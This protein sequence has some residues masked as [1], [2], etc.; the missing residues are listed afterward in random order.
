MTAF[1]T[2]GR[3]RTRLAAAWAMLA[4]AAF[5]CGHALAGASLEWERMDDTYTLS[6]AGFVAHDQGQSQR[7]RYLLAQSTYSDFVLTWRM[8]KR[9]DVTGRPRAIVVFHVADRGKKRR[10]FFL[11]G[12]CREPRQWYAFR[13]VA[14]AGSTALF[15]D[16][17][18]VSRRSS[19]YGEVP[20][21]G[22]VGFLHYYNYDFEYADV[23]LIPLD[24]TLGSALTQFT[25]TALPTGVVRLQWQVLPELQAMLQ[26]AVY[27][28]DSA[29]GPRAST[30]RELAWTDLDTAAGER[31]CYCVQAMTGSGREVGALARAEARVDACEPA[32]PPLHVTAVS[33]IDETVRVSW[34]L[35]PKRRAHTV[36]VLKHSRPI[37][38]A[39][40]GQVITRDAPI[41]QTSYLDASGSPARY[42]AVAVQARGDARA[43]VQCAEAKPSVPVVRRQGRFPMRHPYLL[44]TEQDLRRVQRLAATDA[45]AKRV[46]DRLVNAARKL[47][48]APAPL[49]PKA[50]KRHRSLSGRL[51]QAALGYALCRDETL[52]RW[53]RDAL[54]RYAQL[55][56]KL[57]VV[58][59][60]RRLFPISSLYEATWYVPI[61]LAYDL[62]Y[63]S[64]CFSDRDH[65]RIERDLLRPAAALFKI[66]D[67]ENDPRIRDLHFRCYNFQ[68]WHLAAVGLSGLCLRDAEL[69]DWTLDSPYGLKHLISHDIRD[70]G[71]FW[72]RSLGYHRFVLSALHPLLEAAWH[73]NLDLYHLTVPDDITKDEGGNYVVDRDNGPKS[74]KLMYDAPFYYMFP[75]L[76]FGVVSDSSRGPL[77]TDRRYHAAW[78]RYRDP[79]YAW[80]L[81]RQTGQSSAMWR[82]PQDLSG[83]VRLAYDDQC[84]YVW[85][86]VTDDLV[87]NNHTDPK[88]R[89]MGDLV[90]LGLKFT[91]ERPDEYDSIY[92]LVPGDLASVKPSLMLFNRYREP[93]NEPT[94]GRIGLQSTDQGYRIEAAIPFREMAPKPGEK[95]DALRPTGSIRFEAVLYD[96]D[97]HAGPSVKDKMLGW[98]SVTDRYDTAQGGT[99]IFASGRSPAPR[100]SRDRKI[101]VAPSLQKP[102]C[103][104]GRSG[105]WPEPRDGQVI[106]IED[107]SRVTTDHA[108]SADIHSLVYGRP[109]AGPHQF[110]IGAGAF[111][112]V[113]RARLGSTLFPS[114]GFAV[115]RS[116]GCADWTAGEQAKNKDGTCVLLNFGPH[117]GGHGHPDKLS[118]IVYAK[119]RHWIPDFGSAKYG[120]DLKKQWT[121]HTLSHNTLVVDQTS[122]WPARGQDVSWPCDNPNKRAMGELSAFF[123]DDTLKLASATCDAVYDG[124]RLKR[125]VAL[126]D[127]FV[128]DIFQAA[129]DAE[130]TYDYVLHV[131]G[132]VQAPVGTPIPEPLGKGCGYQHVTELKRVAQ[133]VPWKGEWRNGSD[134][135]K[136]HLLGRAAAEVFEALGPTTTVEKKMAMLLVRETRQSAS[137]VALIEPR[138]AVSGISSAALGDDGRSVE[139]QGVKGRYWFGWDGHGPR[140]RGAFACVKRGRDAVTLSLV[141]TQAIAS[142]GLRLE[143]S[144]PLDAA[145]TLDKTGCSADVLRGGARVVL[146]GAI[147]TAA[148]V[149]QRLDGKLTP[150]P[151]EKVGDTWRFE[152]RPDG[153]YRVCL[154]TPEG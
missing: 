150:F 80:L 78:A 135:L 20:A 82:G 139:A 33:R 10:A 66:D 58:R 152:A 148:Q 127:E 95:H 52:A 141:Q 84:L 99:L 21:A 62:V 34:T 7:D 40:A 45:Q 85:A 51:H 61:V 47:A 13:L 97:R 133:A 110:S 3:G 18:V 67:F 68:A 154:G 102:L 153:E 75:D 126:V 25:A 87:R 130:H 76:T 30:T 90:W 79:K 98:S 108:A 107:G 96:G 111:A 59:G 4:L 128:V 69:V 109:A 94:Q 2:I 122:Q 106:V 44:F 22:R 26:F 28:G 1:T 39:E 41:S 11:A 77:R 24:R 138:P 43:A 125:T 70:D 29:T 144:A 101:C 14:M 145:L 42:Y 27:R 112:N 131:D 9:R 15:R 120:S 49:Y 151:F 71:L 134:R 74:I 83:R 142:E 32:A 31:L 114:S 19:D 86:D 137:F 53:V 146:S 117:G 17:R 81:A 46:L 103:I 104:D 65:E 72:E 89:W 54:L 38:S 115:L 124:V 147:P 57:P 23:R 121:S 149:F 105:D 60:S 6:K 116:A 100:S 88:K 8:R 36:S 50:D 129:S 118:I 123:V 140:F 35:A 5:A 56:V 136:V 64:P 93:T 12:H 55:Y 37:A 119:G 63:E 73:C 92:A 48:A 113:G 16:D 143:C 91:K 132:E